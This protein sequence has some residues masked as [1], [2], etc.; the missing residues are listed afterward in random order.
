MGLL[1]LACPGMSDYHGVNHGFV[2]CP[3]TQSLLHTPCFMRWLTTTSND[4]ELAATLLRL[5]SSDQSIHDH[6]WEAFLH[7]CMPRLM[8]HR[9]LGE[10]H[11]A[12]EFLDCLLRALSYPAVVVSNCCSGADV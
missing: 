10:Q 9:A 6:A 1:L 4:C 2:S 5:G 3:P 7:R 11:D 12:A 8:P